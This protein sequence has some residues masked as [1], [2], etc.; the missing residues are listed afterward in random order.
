MNQQNPEYKNRQHE[1][2][3]DQ[4]F[5]DARQQLRENEAAQPGA[6][7]SDAGEGLSEEER[8]ELQEQAAEKRFGRMA[9]EEDPGET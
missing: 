7:E 6:P 8:N 5:D 4:R 2:V 3:D 1:Q 9:G